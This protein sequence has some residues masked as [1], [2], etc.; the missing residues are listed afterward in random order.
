MSPSIQGTLLSQANDMLSSTTSGRSK[1]TDLDALLEWEAGLVC[2]LSK[3]TFPHRTHQVPQ[4]FH[5]PKD[6]TQLW[7][8]FCLLRDSV[9]Y[10]GTWPKIWKKKKKSVSY[11]LR[12]CSRVSS[13]EE[14]VPLLILWGEWLFFPADASWD[15]EVSFFFLLPNNFLKGWNLPPFFLSVDYKINICCS[16]T[17]LHLG[18]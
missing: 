5:L 15:S 12:L 18:A 7:F 4:V 3:V 1:G 13:S 9:L 10:L 11:Y 16:L 8:C 14:N 17:R 6:R 2:Q